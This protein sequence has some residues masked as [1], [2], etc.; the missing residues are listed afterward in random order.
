[1]LKLNTWAEEVQQ[2][3][4]KH[5]KYLEKLQFLT[6]FIPKYYSKLINSVFSYT[7]VMFQTQFISQK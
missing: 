3:L 5:L 6:F 4:G 2:F 1:M 7:N